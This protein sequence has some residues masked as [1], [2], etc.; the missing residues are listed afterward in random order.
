MDRK[1]KVLIVDD[2]ALVRQVLTEMLNS[3][4]DIEVVGT[5]QDPFVARERIKSLNPDVLTLDVEM[6][7]MDGVTFLRNLMRLRPMPVVMVSTL[8]EKGAD[9]TFQA[10]ELGAVDFVS[11]PKTD[12]AHTLDDYAE[13]IITKVRT[14]AG[15]RVQA[16]TRSL[17]GADDGLERHTADA[18]LGKVSASSHFRTTDRILA[19]GAST[20]G[21]EAIKE[22]LMRLP[23]DTPGTVI[24]QHIPEA[25]SAPFAKRMNGI[26]AMTVCE[27]EDG[28]QIVTG[29]AYIAPGSQ[30][31]LVERDGARYICRLNDGP[32]VNR[33]K[34]S[35]D[36]LFRSVAQNVGS[37]A[38][39]VLLT[40]MGDDGARGMQEMK[41]AGAP[42]I[43][44]DEKSSV[45]WGMPGEAVKLG[46]VDSV[47]S[48]VKIPGHI[49][50]RLKG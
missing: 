30:H 39:S 32:P 18:V 46:C 29:H 48:L 50:Q 36:V 27:A 35:V 3:A 15:A 26:S 28:Q 31:L 19:I 14:A 20:G 8:T 25:F 44:Q 34:P 17:A 33:H 22:V 47:L 10:L 9:I 43:A 49:L 11:K 40:G 12:I 13:E 45:V 41:E 1:I 24:T 16:L 2:S 37:N 38:I 23:A 6:P 21:T 5:A 4:P 7:R 42:T